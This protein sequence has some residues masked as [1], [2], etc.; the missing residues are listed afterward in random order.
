[1]NTSRFIVLNFLVFL[2][3]FSLRLS[4]FESSG[5][6]SGIVLDSRTLQPLIGANVSVDNTA[7]GA[8]TDIEG[9]F[10][11]SGLSPGSYN[12]TI[13]YLGYKIIKKSNVI[14]SPNRTTVLEI[15]MEEDVLQ[16]GEIEIT[17]SYFEKS[18]EAIVSTR[19]MDFEEIRRSPGDLVDIQR[20]VQALPSVTSGADQY[21]EIIVRGGIPGENLFLMDNI[22]IP[23]PNHFAVQ[24]AGGGPI[25]LL[26][27]YMVNSIDFYAG[28]FSSIYGDK[29]SS[30]MNITL[31]N[32][33]F[34]KFR[35][36]GS[37]GM[38]GAG[39]LFEGPIGNIGSYIFSARKSYLDL[40]IS[41]TGLTAVPN[42]YNAQTKMTFN[43]SKNQTLLLNGVYGGDDINIEGEEEAGYGRGAENVDSKGSQW[44]AGLTLRS[45]WANNLYSITTL[46]AVQSNFFVEV[47]DMPGRDVFFTNTSKEREIALKSD[48]TYQ[49][50]K[51]LELSFGGI[52]KNVRFNYNILGD[53]DTLFLYN[54]S[55]PDSI[56]GIERIYPEYRIDQMVNSHKLGGYAQ[57]TFDFLR[58]FRVTAGLR[59]DYFDFNRFQSF[60]PRAGLSYFFSSNT[61]L[62][63]AYGLHY[64][65]PSYVELAAN[66]RNNMLDNKFNEQFVVGIDHLF[67]EDIRLVVE[68]YSKKYFDVP[69]KQVLTTPDPLDFDNGT[70]LNL[71]K[72]YTRGVELFLQKKLV[73]N[74]SAIV[75][76]SYSVARALDVRSNQYYNWDYD[77]R[78]MLTLIAGYRYKFSQHDW[79][80][81]LKSRWWFHLVSWFPLFPSDE[82]E[83]SLKFRYLG[84]RPYTSPVYYPQYQKWLVEE[85]SELNSSR[86]PSYNRLDLRIDKRFAFDNWSFVIF[87]DIV[88]IYNRDNIWSYQYNDDGT[89]ED[90]LQFQTL[91][92]VGVTVEF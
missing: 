87:F 40:I 61:S 75:S 6:I 46:S 85:R 66:E 82:F 20:V 43:L 74:F 53:Q 5:K 29:A 11:I 23:N 7:S 73:E 84:G 3:L 58:S 47:Y 27:S 81:D 32:G 54:P 30:V 1:M 42:Y 49:I 39:A 55:N 65:S 78:H 45:L 18:P 14:V 41:A 79:Y 17:G 89:V 68:A 13:S 19:T 59:Y 60:S 51:G 8:S 21:N 77:Y 86:Y 33:S 88:N 35:G 2:F 10:S 34:E 44:I 70:Y 9:N 36:E 72:G 56:I 91:P 52:Y 92:V 90:V 67:S 12:L 64:Q 63:F 22:E 38:S 16:S 48:F 69:V 71:G 76:Y 80:K 28:A 83:V 26:N 25:N 15:K 37:I 57:L 4:A 50:Q 31:R 62:N 24:G